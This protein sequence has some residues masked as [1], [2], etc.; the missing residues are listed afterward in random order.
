MMMMTLGAKWSSGSGGCT[1]M[2]SDDWLLCANDDRDD[3]DD[4]DYDYN[5]HDDD[6]DAG[7]QMVIGQRGL[8]WAALGRPSTVKPNALKLYPLVLTYVN[9]MMMITMI[10]ME[11]C[12]YVYGAKCW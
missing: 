8:Y 10:M 6:D 5:D 12:N 9:I 1:E 4:N 11:N 7:C 2:P 3:D